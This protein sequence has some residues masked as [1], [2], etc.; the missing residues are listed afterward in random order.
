[1]LRA[2][3]QL[4]PTG[5]VAPAATTN[6]PSVLFALTALCAL[7]GLPGAVYG[8]TTDSGQITDSGEAMPTWTGAGP[9]PAASKVDLQL[10]GQTEVGTLAQAESAA[11]AGAPQPAAPAQPAAIQ[12]TVDAHATEE[13]KQATGHFDFG[14]YGRV[15]AA[16]DLRGKVGR[17]SNIVAFG[18]RN[19]LDNYA[20]LEFRRED[21]VDGL[22]MKTVATLALAGD[23][24]HLDGEFQEDLAVRN[25]FT[26]VNHVFI[27][28]LA[29]WAG[30]RMVRGDDVYLL[31]FWP[32]DNLNL[33]GGGARYVDAQWEFLLHGGLTRPNNPFYKQTIDVVP[34]FG[35]T[36]ASYDL[37]DRPRSVVAAKATYFP[38]GRAASAFKASLYG[39]AHRLPKGTRESEQNAIQRLPADNGLV[40]GAQ[41]GGWLDTPRSFVNLFLRYAQG[42]AVYDPL[43]TPM[44]IGTV[45]SASDAKELRLALSANYEQG[46]LGVQLGG[47]VRD[48]RDGSNAVLSGGH[49]IDGAVDVRPYIWFG[50][51]AGLSLDAGYQ[52]VALSTLD[53]RTGKPVSGSVTKVAVIPFISPYGRGTYTRPHIHLI[54]QMSLR[55][56]GAQAL[57]PARDPRSSQST[58]HFFAVGAEWWFNS[59]SY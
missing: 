20:E 10:E 25:L 33:I 48:L 56:D 19:D 22:E 40:A 28:G 21:N 12:G 27:K 6:G 8:Q 55:N 16:S 51:Y 46:M 18:P 53:D 58:E 26:E 41:L 44:Q 9:A 52:A 5:G 13:Q 14:S 36:P 32:L 59:S 42:I 24:F 23:F 11:P 3:P 45:T 15:R 30:S 35:F 49:L 2:S 34:A 38:F 54:Y 39:E 37:L 43:S 57:Y 1:M 29:F 47:Y 4:G 31:N 7:L 50:N 17:N